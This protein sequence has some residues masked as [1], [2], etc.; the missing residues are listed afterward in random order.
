MQQNHTLDEAGA[1]VGGGGAQA[2]VEQKGPTCP[3][4]RQDAVASMSGAQGGSPAPSGREYAAMAAT[5]KGAVLLFG[6]RQSP[7][8][9]LDDLWV[10]PH[11]GP[12]SGWLRLGESVHDTLESENQRRHERGKVGNDAS[13]STPWPSARWGHTLLN[14]GGDTVRPSNV[15]VDALPSF[16]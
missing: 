1:A 3:T 16:P 9:P 13:C 12:G 15:L 11:L 10:L 4:E 5:E 2:A 8:S 14:V 6:G 7:A